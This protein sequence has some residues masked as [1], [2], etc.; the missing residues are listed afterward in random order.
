MSR[1]EPWLKVWPPAGYRATAD[2]EARSCL[3]PARP[4][5]QGG[6]PSAGAHWR[7]AEASE[8]AQKRRNEMFELVDRFE[9]ECSWME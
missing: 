8:A 9:L 4:L 1:P 2:S 3:H 7:L 6:C 5:A